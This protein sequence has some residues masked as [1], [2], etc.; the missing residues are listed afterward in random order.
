MKKSERANHYQARDVAVSNTSSRN[1]AMLVGDENTPKTQ[2]EKVYIDWEGKN[3]SSYPITTTLAVDM[4]RQ[5]W[6]VT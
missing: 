5:E 6:R 3:L 4:H 1:L 2:I